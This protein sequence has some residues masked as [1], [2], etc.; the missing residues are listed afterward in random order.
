MPDWQSGTPY[1]WKLL[2]PDRQSDCKYDTITSARSA[3][4]AKHELRN[5]AV[6]VIENA[7][8]Y[9]C[10]ISLATYDLTVVQIPNLYSSTV[11]SQYLNNFI[12]AIMNLR[13]R[14]IFTVHKCLF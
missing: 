3:K 13:T 8:G 6:E 14:L 10:A 9:K 12:Y 11:H 7:T 2:A 4:I 1:K 5:K